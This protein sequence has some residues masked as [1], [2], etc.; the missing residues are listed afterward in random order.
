MM[1]RV[2]AVFMRGGTSRALFFH[3]RDL[4][5]AGPERDAIFLAALGSPDPYGRQLDGL[6]GGISSLSK[7]CVIGPPTHA[8]A[9]V[10]YT[11]AQV[12]VRSPLVDYAGNCGN[13]SS[14][15]GPFAIDEGLVPARE[16][17]TPVRIHN[18]NTRKLILAHVP[19]AGG[20]A[21]VRGDFELAGVPGRGARIA[22]D[23]LDPGG[24]GTGRLLPTGHARDVVE[25]L[26]AS[27]VDATNPMVFVRA[28][29]V[30]LT[31][32]E[33]PAAIDGDQAVTA[34]LESIRTA[35]ARLMGL[36]PGPA[37]P[38]VA[39]VA[40][41]VAFTALD[42]APHAAAQVDL[43]ARV[44]S[45]GNCHR[46]F[47]LTA[48]MCLAV[49]ARIDGTVVQECVASP[50]G[51][52]RLGHPSGVLPVAATVGRRD[53]QPWAEQVTVYRTARRLMDGFVH[54]P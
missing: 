10:D 34:R 41:A 26:E 15:V 45:M 30:G 53:G 19:V 48:A 44:M 9:D 31:G 4:P 11:F 16:P 37:V 25:G 24:A 52:V 29:D 2:R 6:G 27:L 17:E 21:A 43:L 38:K 51:D 5:P 3:Q 13:C 46:A 28:K 20:E 7:C 39:V 36:A 47:A 22:L 50:A 23:F 8:D 49:A 14:A 40:P 12:D 32:A 54:L 33:P 18:T 42:G 1:N 35:A